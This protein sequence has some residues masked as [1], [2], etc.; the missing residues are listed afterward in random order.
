MFDEVL[1]SYNSTQFTK[2]KDWL[3]MK[4]ILQHGIS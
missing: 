3:T 4:D 1:K 2:S